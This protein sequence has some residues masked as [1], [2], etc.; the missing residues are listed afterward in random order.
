MVKNGLVEEDEHWAPQG[1]GGPLK[2]FS[3]NPE[4]VENY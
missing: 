4:S 2:H 1:L 3:L